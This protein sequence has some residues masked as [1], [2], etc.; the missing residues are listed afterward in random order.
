MLRE[1]ALDNSGCLEL[2][3]ELMSVDTER[4]NQMHLVMQLRLRLA[5]TAL[6]LCQLH[7][8]QLNLPLEAHLLE[9]RHSEL[10]LT[11]RKSLPETLRIAG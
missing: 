6:L 3:F 4:G 2:P 10:H 8:K 5:C 11:I 1:R 7:P 9:R